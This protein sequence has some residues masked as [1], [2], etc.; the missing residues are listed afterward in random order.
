MSN[1]FHSLQRALD[2]PLS[3][4]SRLVLL[5][6]IAALVVGAFLPLWRIQLVAPQYQEGLT[7][8]MYTY[9][10]VAG[11]GGN[12]LQEINTLNHYIGMKPIAEADFIEMQWIPFAI[13]A[14]VLLALRAAV[15]GR[16]TTVVDLT[17]LFC[18]FSAFSL[19]SFAY[20]LYTYGHHLDPKAPMTIE[21]FMPVLIG[22]QQI[23]NFVQTSLPLWGSVSLALFLP[24]LLAAIWLSRKETAA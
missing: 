2:R 6:G 21:P 10:I 13:G 7:L 22:S 14:F 17:V 5:A 1:R 12:D 3:G 18:Y 16:L 8:E 24:A 19:G 4:R 20:R 9:K 15:I 11:N 23:A